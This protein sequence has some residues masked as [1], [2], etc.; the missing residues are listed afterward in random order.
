[1]RIRHPRNLTRGTIVFAMILGT[2]AGAYIWKPLLKEELSKR[3]EEQTD[4][5]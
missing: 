4:I 1:M 5:K 3:A 2:I